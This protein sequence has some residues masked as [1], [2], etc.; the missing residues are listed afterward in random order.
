MKAMQYLFPP[1]QHAFHLDG[2]EIEEIELL[3][4]SIPVEATGGITVVDL[5][6]IDSLTLECP[7]G[8]SSWSDVFLQE[9]KMSHEK[10]RN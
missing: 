10:S 4:M 5:G 9:R 8:F 1:P 2:S 3:A 6:D 7:K